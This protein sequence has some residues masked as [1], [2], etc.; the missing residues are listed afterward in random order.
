MNEVQREQVALF[1]FG[2]IGALVSGELAHGELKQKL[3]ELSSRRYT[4]PF[5]RRTSIGFGTLEEWLSAYRHRGF[6][7]LKPMVR[8]DHGRIKVIRPHLKDQLLMLKREHPRLS[9]R[10]I[11]RKLV[12][13]NVMRPGEVSHTTIYRLFSREGVKRR[14]AKS[15]K[16]Q[17]RF[18]YR[19]PN[20][21]WQGDVMHG[22][23]IKD[24]QSRHSRKTYLIAFIDDASRLIVGAEFFFA[25]TAAHTK[26]VLRAAVQTYG[27]PARLYLDNGK[28]F[29]ADGIRLACARMNTALIHTTPY[30]PEGKGKIERFFRT[31][32]S[33]FLP[34][35]RNVQ[36]LRDMNVCFEL[37]LQNE[38]NRAAH[39]ALD[40]NARPLDIF[41]KNIEGRLRRFPRHVDPTE[42]FCKKESR[43]VAKD[44]TFR[45]NN[46][47]YEAEEQLIGQKID[48]LFDTDHPT[49]MVKVFH[50]G[51]YIHSATPVD[52]LAN[53]IAKR[54]KRPS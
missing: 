7:G 11:T 44:G 4:I 36:S 28:N 41:L 27:V 29:C 43:L 25:E 32:R 30:Y 10:S 15:G 9:A 16:E 42:L 40:D 52:Y 48:V 50:H 49:H 45:V 46:I 2:V 19:Y 47:L 37:W 13:R 24:G 18:E 1:R 6:D 5:S 23:Y 22:P 12:Q 20:D 21:C 26:S 38:Y 31:V 39:S 8:N 17:K 34:W 51:A 54:K 35:L 3:Q 14:A 53:S 33:C